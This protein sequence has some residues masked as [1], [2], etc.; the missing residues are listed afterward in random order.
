MLEKKGFVFLLIFHHTIYHQ[1]KNCR[2]N[3]VASSENFKK[4]HL[5]W[6]FVKKKRRRANNKYLQN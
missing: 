1:L 3:I 6:F 2:C 4:V 5:K